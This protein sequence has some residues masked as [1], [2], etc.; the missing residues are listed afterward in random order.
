MVDLTKTT[1]EDLQA[2]L[3]RR[4]KP[5]PKPIPFVRPDF[6]AVI[7]LAKNY[8][9]DL[10][11]EGYVVD[12]YGDC[13]LEAVLLAVFGKDIWEWTNPILRGGIDERTD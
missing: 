1:T 9:D 7:E 10:D 5:P 8:I 2:E 6:V 13:M 3:E 12:D 11:R 4:E